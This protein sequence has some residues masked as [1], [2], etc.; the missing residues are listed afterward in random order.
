MMSKVIFLDAHRPHI[1]GT[2]VCRNCGNEHVYVAPLQM[3]LGSWLHLEC[4][5][6]GKPVCHDKNFNVEHSK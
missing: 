1:T 6:C 4:N 5:K 2:A 3:E